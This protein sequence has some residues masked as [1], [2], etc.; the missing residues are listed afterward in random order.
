MSS[1]DNHP[2]AADCDSGTPPDYA[3]LL[4][5]MQHFC[6]VIARLRSPTGCPWDRRQT[7]KS[8]KPYTLEETYELLEAIDSDDNDAICE[9]LGDV[10]LQ[11]VLD[12]QIARD[13]GRFELTDVV[14]RA[15]EK[16]VRRHPHVF[17]DAEVETTADV[18]SLWAQ[19]KRDEKPDRTSRLEGIPAA[20]PQLARAAR[21]SARAASVGYDFPDRRMLFDKLNEELTELTA[22]LFADG[23]VTTV[24]AEVHSAPIADEPIT[25]PRQR[26]RVEAELGD[27]LFVLANIARRWGVNPEEALRHSNAKFARRFEAIEAAM[28]ATG[29]SLDEATLIEMEEAYQAAKRRESKP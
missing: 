14:A 24:P 3:R 23:E 29:R 9:E 7:M 28:R 19:V 4:P 15:A 16:M 22:E 11:V 6:D 2:A 13:E 10:L 17:G 1:A 27:V 21:L 20:L 25:D 8:I 18:K 12:A 5:A 26:Q